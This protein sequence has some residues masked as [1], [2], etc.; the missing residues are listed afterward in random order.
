MK[1]TYVAPQIV[2]LGD[3]SSYVQANAHYSQYTDPHGSLCD[4][5]PAD[6]TCYY[7]ASL[8]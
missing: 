4:T 8:G 2:E 1:K 6:S 3:V 7:V 5:N